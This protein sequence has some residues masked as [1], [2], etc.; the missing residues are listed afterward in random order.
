MS[1]Y[2][3]FQLLQGSNKRMIVE[4]DGGQ[5]SQ[6]ATWTVIIDIKFTDIHNHTC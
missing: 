2:R 3:C 1:G 5:I 4:P 6:V